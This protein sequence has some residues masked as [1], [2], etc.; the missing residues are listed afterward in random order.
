MLLVERLK[1]RK[2]TMPCPRPHE[3]QGA[4]LGFELRY[5][6]FFKVLPSEHLPWGQLCVGLDV[7]GS[8]CH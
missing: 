7:K 6:A 3:Q 5:F 8:L 4:T 2:D 1:L